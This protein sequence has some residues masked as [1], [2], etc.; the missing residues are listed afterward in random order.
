MRLPWERGRREVSH[1]SRCRPDDQGLSPS[2]HRRRMGASRGPQRTDGGLAGCGR[3]APQSRELVTIDAFGQ[4][5][6]EPGVDA[7][8][9]R[10]RCKDSDKCGLPWTV[11]QLNAVMQA[12]DWTRVR[13]KAAP[14]N[15][16]HWRIG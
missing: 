10:L 14:K 5:G 1:R 12:P 7:T 6:W 3:R 2:R 11:R 13:L 8:F 16:Q 15:V 9:C 4:R